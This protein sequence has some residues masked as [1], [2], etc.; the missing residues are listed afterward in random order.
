MSVPY[1]RSFRVYESTSSPAVTNDAA[2]GFARYD[3]WYETDAGIMWECTDATTGAAVWQR[4]GYLP[5]A[6][7]T[8]G[9]VLTVNATADGLEWKTPA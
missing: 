5:A 3:R 1:T 7:G 9:Q 4:V 2:H 8:A 6:L